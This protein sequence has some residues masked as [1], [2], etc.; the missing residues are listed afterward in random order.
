MTGTELYEV[1]DRIPRFAAACA[2]MNMLGRKA[3]Q[4]DGFVCKS[5]AGR[6]VR[7]IQNYDSTVY[8]HDDGTPWEPE[9]L[10]A[11]WRFVWSTD[12]AKALPFVEL[13]TSPYMT[14]DC[15][16]RDGHVWRSGQ[17]TNTWAPGTTGVKWEDL[18]TVE[19]VM[20]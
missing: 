9:E 18:G 3:G 14:G 20:G 7:L 17:D 19:E 2:K 13:A 1:D 6:V 16:T 5:T 15:C 11:Q 8:L 4:T 12:P 10:P